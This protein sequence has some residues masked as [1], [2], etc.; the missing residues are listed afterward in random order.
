VPCYSPL[1]GWIDPESKG[2][3]F[4]KPSED[5]MEVACGQCLGCRLDRARMWSIRM[6][7]EARMHDVSSFITLTYRDVD[8]PP[9]WSLS[10]PVRENGKQVQQSQF[11]AFMKRLRK[12]RPGQKIKYFMCGEYGYKCSHDVFLDE[13]KCPVG[14]KVG[15]PHYH[16]ILFNCDFQDKEIHGINKHGDHWY[17][18]RELEELWPYG[19]N[20]I[21]DVTEQSA[22]YV[23]RY[24]LKK[25]TGELA[26][27]HYQ[28]VDENGEIHQLTPEYAT[29][30]NG[31]GLEWYKKYR[32]DVWPHDEIPLPTGGVSKSVPRFY[33]E[34]LRKEDEEE[35]ELVKERRKLFMLEN[36]DEYSPERLQSKYRVKKAAT[37]TLKRRE[38]E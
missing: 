26:D 24:C 36:A 31:I 23:A 1:K 27:E 18:S 7:Y 5:E 11:Q 22:G 37:S 25:I 12:R 28:R 32:S 38:I 10:A 21:G 2:I 13:G 29:M 4:Q 6:V 33:C 16:A 30:S 19:F 34:Q 35:Y 17:T 20:V 14:C 15:R 8:L 9:D 3:Q